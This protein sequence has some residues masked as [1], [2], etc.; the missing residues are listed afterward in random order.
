MYQTAGLRGGRDRDR[1]CD[2]YHVKVL[3]MLT[4][5]CLPQAFSVSTTLAQPLP[6]LS[7]FFHRL[8]PMLGADSAVPFDHT[9]GLPTTLLTNRLKIDSRH[10]A[11]ARPMMAP[12]VHA[13]IGDAGAIARGLVGLGG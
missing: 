12:V 2:P 6:N 3:R 4:K 5:T 8:S 10:D 9:Q 13:K 1:T 11:L 7:Q